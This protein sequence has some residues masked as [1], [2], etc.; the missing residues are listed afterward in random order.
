MYW[1]GSPPQGGCVYRS[2]HT[3][4]LCLRIAK[5]ALDQKAA[6]SKA[7]SEI[8][9]QSN[10]YV[11]VGGARPRARAVLRA[12]AQAGFAVRVL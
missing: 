1:Y 9:S 2:E 8:Y 5:N 12:D 6:V 11:G 10:N 7:M 4:D 3:T